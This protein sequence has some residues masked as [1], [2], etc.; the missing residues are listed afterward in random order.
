MSRVMRKSV[1]SIRSNIN[2]AVQ[3]QKMARGLKFRIRKLEE[4]YFVCREYK[5]A[6]QLP[7][8]HAADLR[9]CF[10]ICKFSHDAAQME[11]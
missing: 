5:E 7:S 10:R 11:A 3:P 1:F 6:D 4:F 2:H 8:Y 9:L